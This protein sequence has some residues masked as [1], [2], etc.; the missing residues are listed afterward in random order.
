MYYLMTKKKS[1][2]QDK[3]RATAE[4]KGAEV[5]TKEWKVPELPLIITGMRT[6]PQILTTV[7]TDPLANQKV[8]SMSILL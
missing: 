2:N 1:L 4:P 3:H 8:T 6:S 5:A 7:F